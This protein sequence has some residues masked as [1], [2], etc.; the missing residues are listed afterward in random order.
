MNNLNLIFLILFIATLQD[1]FYRSISNFLPLAIIIVSLFELDFYFVLISISLS[2]STFVLL[3]VVYN[4]L[5]GGDLKMMASLTPLI[6]HKNITIENFCIFYLL[7]SSFLLIH[8][9]AYRVGLLKQKS[10]IFMPVIF[11]SY[12]IAFIGI[13]I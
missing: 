2:I 12:F 3:A 10:F 11:I 7:L 9:S 5:G 13:T 4:N 8:Y 1:I 6:F